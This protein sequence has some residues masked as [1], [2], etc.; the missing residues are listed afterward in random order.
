MLEK[1]QPQS[2][3]V[4]DSHRSG[5]MNGYYFNLVEILEPSIGE[6]KTATVAISTAKYTQAMV[7]AAKEGEYL[8]PRWKI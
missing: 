1:F 4:S 2:T 6:W 7:G 5:D 3:R 8:Q